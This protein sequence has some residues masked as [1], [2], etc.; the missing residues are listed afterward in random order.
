MSYFSYLIL[1]EKRTIHHPKRKNKLITEENDKQWCT[2]ADSQINGD[3]N[4]LTNIKLNDEESSKDYYYY[5]YHYQYPKNM[6]TLSY[7]KIVEDKKV[8]DK[9][10]EAEKP[11]K[12]YYGWPFYLPKIVYSSWH[13]KMMTRNT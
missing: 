9:K 13:K 5:G 8:E 10:V 1:D 2:D 3:E 6:C 12:T 4:Q 7:N 11:K